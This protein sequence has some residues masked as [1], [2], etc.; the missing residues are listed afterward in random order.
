MKKQYINPEMEVI[1]IETSHQLLAGS[2]DSLPFD[3]TGKNEVTK[4][5]SLDVDDDPLDF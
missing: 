5:L 1:T 2:S 4:G 3:S